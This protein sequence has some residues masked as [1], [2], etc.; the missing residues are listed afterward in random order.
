MKRS[1]I[2]FDKDNTLLDLSSYWCLPIHR[3]S[4]YHA[5]LFHQSGNLKLI[6]ALDR[7]AGFENGHLIPESPVCAGTNPDVI[8]AQAAVLEQFHCFLSCEQQEQS[9]HQLELFC[10]EYG[11]AVSVHGEDL[12]G[13]LCDLRQKQIVLGVAT[14]DD[15]ASAMHCLKLL[16]IHQYFDL[17]LSRDQV[18]YA[19]PDPEMAERFMETFHLSRAH[20]WMVGDSFNDMQFASNS[21]IHGIL[22]DPDCCHQQIDSFQ[23]IHSLEKLKNI[24]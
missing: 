1:G 11:K 15:S 23:I 17:V 22:Y 5:A 10:I 16:G 7:S 18:E 21:G 24:F 8:H 13:V 9:V 4:E 19:K 20:T 3:L 2:L 6:E 12:P 14:S